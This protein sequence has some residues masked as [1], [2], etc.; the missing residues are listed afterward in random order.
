MGEV[1]AARHRAGGEAV[2]VKVIT[3]SRALKPRFQ[4]AFRNEARAMAGM[5]HPGIARV[6]DFGRI[7]TSTAIEANGAL[8]DG[9][10]YLAMERLGVRLDVHDLTRGWPGLRTVLLDLLDALAHAHARGLVH[11]DL[12]PDNILWTIDGARVKLTDFGVAHAM[13]ASHAPA[14]LAVVGVSTTLE[15]EVVGTEGMVGT[16]NYMAPEQVR[17]L[18]WAQ[19]PWTDLYALGCIAYE[20]ACG[21]APFEQ[22]ERPLATMMA[23]VTAPIPALTPRISLPEGFGPFVAR[24]LAKT[25]EARFRKAADAAHALR[26]LPELDLVMSIDSVP[27]GPG[28]SAEYTRTFVDTHPPSFIE[29]ALLD[30]G[31]MPASAEA[32]RQ[33]RRPVP[34]D[35]RGEE[36]V[37]PGVLRGVGLG[38]F[39]L[40]RV[41]FI[42]REAERDLLWSTL[43][44]V[45]AEGSARALVL[46]GP[47]GFGKS[48]LAEWLLERADELGAANSLRAVHGAVEGP[49]QGLPGM[50]ERTLRCVELPREELVEHV[51]RML[52]LLDAREPN[53]AGALAE[54]I[55]PT[56]NDARASTGGV[57]F[58]R[59]D[60][61]YAVV[62]RFLA[63]LSEERPVL[64]MLDDV[65]WSRR[66]LEFTSHVLEAQATDPFPALFVLTVRDDALAERPDTTDRLGTLLA[67]GAVEVPI[68][69]I[70]EGDRSALLEALLG[71]ESPLARSIEERTAGNALFAVQLVGD[72]VQRGVLTATPGGFRLRPGA[73]QALPPDIGAVWQARIEQLLERRSLG[74]A[75]ALELAAV[76]GLHVSGAEWRLACLSAGLMPDAGLVEAL[77][78]AALARHGAEG[79]E[80]RWSFAHGMLRE[81]IVQRARLAGRLRLHHRTCAR[82]IARQ[83]GP[84]TD[85]RV[86]RHLLEAGERQQAVP[87]L[88]SAAG[89]RLNE[90]DYASATELLDRWDDA[91]GELPASDTNWGEGWLL[92]SRLARMLGQPDEAAQFAERAQIGARTHGWQRLQG[93]TLLEQGVL[94]KEQGQLGQAEALLRGALTRA[95]DDESL[96]ARCNE[97]LGIIQLRGGHRDR[98][99]E[100][101]ESA[102]ASFAASGDAFGTGRCEFGLSRVR[103]QAGQISVARAHLDEARLAFQSAGAR[104]ALAATRN[105]DGECARLE[106]DLTAAAEHY[107]AALQLW[108]SMGAANAEYARV[109][110]GLTLVEA[111]RCEEARPLLDVARARFLAQ[112][113]WA[114]L[115]PCHAALVVVNAHAGDWAAFDHHLS[116]TTRL[117][118]EMQLADVDASRLI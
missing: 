10:L 85:E 49:G 17:G 15:W 109:N 88:L 53:A 48:R 34:E 81:A 111:G 24:L 46:R 72:F 96:R 104:N 27:V 40:R 42:G 68:G 32:E 22:G 25:P 103:M 80:V 28:A 51:D 8:P 86:A 82:V 18:P 101:F 23:H 76:L 61:H 29:A 100:F 107:R 69:P 83:R 114:A 55:A 1:W 30:T 105:M 43:R 78:D 99:A 90:G 106:G 93:A 74:D 84:R 110:L 7:D 108:D 21:R 91:M 94:N 57:T 87:H 6:Y 64:V 50:L 41:P 16:P 62:R 70:A 31:P 77:I 33:P 13:F 92:H 38:L 26:S 9:G 58:G 39:G 89:L 56:P 115:A 12:K 75:R 19:G 73:T 66:A 36:T 20:I 3:D 11:R 63:R 102:R 95:G 54:I 2:A 117:L 112:Q 35:W 45:D 71:L 4:A 47:S 59:P 97:E 79:P 14:S 118:D 116:E 37:E 5:Q 65:Q 60:E 44:A 67:Q 113:R 98:A 52:G